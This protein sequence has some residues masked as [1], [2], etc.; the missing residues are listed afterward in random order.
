MTEKQQDRVDELYAY[1]V[2]TIS[3]LIDDLLSVEDKEIQYALLVKLQ[4]QFRFY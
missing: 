4:K 2:E 3:E 1:V